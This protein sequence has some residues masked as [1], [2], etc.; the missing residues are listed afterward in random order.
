[1]NVRTDEKFDEKFDIVKFIKES[2]IFKDSTKETKEKL[3]KKGFKSDHDDEFFNLKFDDDGNPSTAII[4][5]LPTKIDPSTLKK[6]EKPIHVLTI[7]QHFF[8]LPDGN[9]FVETCPGTIGKPCP[10]CKYIQPFWDGSDEDMKKYNLMRKKKLYF[11]NIFIVK[12]ASDPETEKKVKLFKLSKMLVD[13]IFQRIP[14]NDKL[15]GTKNEKL[16]ELYFDPFDPFKSAFFKLKWFLTSKAIDGRNRMVPDFSGSSFFE[17][18]KP[19]TESLYRKIYERCFNLKE[20]LEWGEYK[21]KEYDELETLFK[22]GMSMSMRLAIDKDLK[23]D[24]VSMDTIEKEIN[25]IEQFGVDDENL[26]KELKDSGIEF[27]DED[28]DIPSKTKD[29]D[30]NDVIDMLSEDKDE[31]DINIESY[32]E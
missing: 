6:N 31:G 25:E 27:D 5:F 2:K 3:T 21:V 32:L 4:R 30:E 23:A 28:I 20:I 15:L 16:G 8:R 18:I 24:N 1:M 10:I 13:L 19:L 29:I 7:F 12:N 11:T 14:Q 22:N 9:F 26:K 17:E